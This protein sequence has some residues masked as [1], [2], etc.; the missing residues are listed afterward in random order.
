MGSRVPKPLKLLVS[1]VPYLRTFLKSFV[2]NK[3][4]NPFLNPQNKNDEYQ[5][6]DKN[7]YQIITDMPAK[8]KYKGYWKKL[9]E[10]IKA[11]KRI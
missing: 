5:N 1:Q 8:G 3:R 10:L 2:L 11:I 4:E 7:F 6:A 9:L